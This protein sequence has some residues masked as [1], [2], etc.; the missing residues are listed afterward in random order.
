MRA[1][2]RPTARAPLAGAGGPPRRAPRGAAAQVRRLPPPRPPPPAPRSGRLVP[3]HRA[4]TVTR[5]AGWAAPA[6]ARAEPRARPETNLSRRARGSALRVH[7]AGKPA[8]AAALPPAAATAPVRVQH[9][10]ARAQPPPPPRRFP[11]P[12]DYRSCRGSVPGSGRRPRAEGGREGEGGGA[13]RPG[14]RGP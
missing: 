12:R 3:P 10:Q 5:P 14:Q 2:P 11:A 6:T 7:E 1:G 4:H 9:R 8:P 13:G